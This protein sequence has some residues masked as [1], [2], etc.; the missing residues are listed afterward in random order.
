VELVAE[1]LVGP[2]LAPFEQDL[3]FDVDLGPDRLA[4][5]QVKEARVIVYDDRLPTSV[6][7][8]LGAAA[9]GVIALISGTTVLLFGLLRKRRGGARRRQNV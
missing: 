2:Y 4:K 7:V 6:T 1:R 5:A 9:G 8:A 3:T